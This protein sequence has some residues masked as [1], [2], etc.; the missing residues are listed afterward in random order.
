MARISHAAT[1]ERF[2]RDLTTA[3]NGPSPVCADSTRD[4]LPGAR[5]HPCVKSLATR[6]SA[7]AACASTGAFLLDD[8][9]FV[10]KIAPFSLR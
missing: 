2:R 3:W 8:G 7:P 6:S 10:K 1:L 9:A 5:N 4:L